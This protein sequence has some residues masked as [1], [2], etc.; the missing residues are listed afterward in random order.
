VTAPGYDVPLHTAL[1]QPVLMGGVP[2]RVFILNITVALILG[3]GLKVWWLAPPLALACHGAAAWMAKR[4][5]HYFEALRRHV[6]Q[7]SFFDA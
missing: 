2:R 4:D 5:P 7:P 6:W 3:L 1:T